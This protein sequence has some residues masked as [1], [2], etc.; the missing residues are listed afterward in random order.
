MQETNTPTQMQVMPSKQRNYNKQWQ[1]QPK[2][3][4]SNPTNASKCKVLNKI[5]QEVHDKKQID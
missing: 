4:M 5:E 2:D 1:Q 3:P